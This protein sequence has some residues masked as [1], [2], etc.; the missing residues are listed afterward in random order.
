MQTD[1]LKC[2]PSFL[3]Q[4]THNAA[5]NKPV[6]YVYLLLKLVI[7]GCTLSILSVSEVSI[8]TNNIN[9]YDSYSY[10]CN[11]KKD[12]QIM[13]LMNFQVFFEKI[14]VTHPWKALFVSSDDDIGEWW[15]KW[16]LDRYRYS[17]RTNIKI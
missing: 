2:V 17:F 12:K 10:N 11:R 16:K 13:K 9:V 7:L 15:K 8:Q 5:E 3:F 6:R 14:F 4:V 1:Y